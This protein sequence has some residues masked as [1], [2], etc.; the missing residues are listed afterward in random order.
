MA[1]D[2]EIVKEFICST[3]GFDGGDLG[4]PENRSIWLCGIE[5]GSGY[6]DGKKL[7]DDIKNWKQEQEQKQKYKSLKELENERF[8]E[9][10]K[11]KCMNFAYTY[12]NK[13]TRLLSL[14][15]HYCESQNGDFK[16]DLD[17]DEKAM[18]FNDK[19]EPFVLKEKQTTK[20][21]QGFFKLNLYPIAFNNTRDKKSRNE[22]LKNAEIGFECDSDY[23]ESCKNNRF[24]L[25]KK[26]KELHKPKIII[27]VGF[28]TRWEFAEAFFGKKNYELKE[29][30]YD[31]DV[32]IWYDTKND[33]DTLFVVIK[34]LSDMGSCLNN[35]EKINK[36][37]Y[38]IAQKVKDKNINL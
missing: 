12:N 8:Y 28:G 13:A 31:N 16:K 32:S 14:L 4:C 21:K 15:F 20:E 5:W 17:F 2:E 35:D 9:G 24:P 19:Y 23:K 37:A 29:D 18:E 3:A 22:I 7:K 38:L 27:C 1:L 11:Y 10:Y 6:T 34:F 26:L 30:K 25:L 33:D 36:C